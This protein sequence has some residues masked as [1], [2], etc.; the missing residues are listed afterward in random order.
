MKLS[1]ATFL[2]VLIMMTRSSNSLQWFRM[3]SVGVSGR[4]LCEGVPIKKEYVLVELRRILWTSDEI[5]GQQIVDV[6]SGNFSFYGST[7]TIYDSID[8]ALFIY[9]RCNFVD[10][11]FYQGCYLRTDIQI[12]NKYTMESQTAIE[13]FNVGSIELTNQKSR[14]DCKLFFL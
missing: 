9:H 10:D 7:Y 14:H 8:T 12:P 3:V 11:S 6:I 5:L 2:A 13:Y 4:I 1:F